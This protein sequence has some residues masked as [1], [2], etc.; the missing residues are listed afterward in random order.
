MWKNFFGVFYTL[1]S[2]F[3]SMA[4]AFW[5]EFLFDANCIFLG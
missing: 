1:I 4:L 2:F 5:A 3:G